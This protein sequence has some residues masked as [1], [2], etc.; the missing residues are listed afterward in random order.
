MTDHDITHDTETIE[1]ESR[2]GG[3]FP[4]SAIVDQTEMKRALVLNAVNRDVGGVLI[5]GERGTAKSTA[6]RALAEVLPDI[7]AVADCPYSCPPTDP[8]RMCDEC[9]ER[10]DAGEDLPIETRPMRV[11]DLPLNASEDRVVG[12]IDLER[13]VQAGERDFEPGI[14]AEANRNILYVDEVNLLDDHIVDV[15]LDAAAMGENIVEREGVSF[16]HPSEFILVGTM[17]PEEGDLRPQLLDRFG[18]V[19]DVEGVNEVDDRVEISRRRA[20][21]EADPEAFRAEYAEEQA[22]L[23]N[24]IATAR[25]RLDEVELDDDIARLIAGMNIE[26][27]VD[28]HRGD[29]TLRRAARTLAAYEGADEVTPRTVRR[30][31][32]MALEHRLQRLPFEEEEQDVLSVFHDVRRELGLED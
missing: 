19:V 30:V 24:D 7:E 9:R 31:A 21:F 22:A 17:N 18:L 8:D 23:R 32:R 12:S 13:A 29:I 1:D 28:G 26:L 10:Y 20:E 15:L 25:E 4:F 27:D 3:T 6:V 16:R 2:A 11:V 14:L 5:R